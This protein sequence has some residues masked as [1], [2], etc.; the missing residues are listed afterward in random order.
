MKVT[1]KRGVHLSYA[2]K[3]ATKSLPV[4]D[5]VSDEV[6]IIM[7]MHIGAPSV[8]CVKKGDHVLLGQVIA[9]PVGFLGIPVH[10]SV[11][12]EVTDVGTIPY[13]G[14]TPVQCVTI[15][16]DFKDEWAPLTPL[17]DV[18]TVDPALIVPA[19]KNA[20]ICGMGGASFP[21]H[22]KLSPKP[23][24]KCELVIVNGAECE[25]HLTCDHRLM[26]EEGERIV[27]GLRA[28]MRALSV[29]RGVI[30]IEDNKPDAIENMRR[31]CATRSGVSVQV[32]K[33]K[34]PQGGEKQLIEAVTGRQVPVGKLPI[35][36]GAVVCNV[37]TCA[38]ISDAIRLGRPLIS[39]ITTVTGCV[40]EPANLRVRIG[41][42]AED[43]IGAC[44]GFS[45][46]A[47]KVAFGGGM[48]GLCIPNT[49]IPTAKSTNGIV[50]YNEKDAKSI[51]EGPC[52]RCGKCVAACPIGLNPYLI[53]R[54]ADA[55]RLDE[56]ARLSVN[57]CILCGCC[58]YECPSRRW[59]TA[60]F[61]IVKQ[62]LAAQA[63]AKGGKA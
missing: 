15:K 17:G 31:L 55:D 39:R 7:N 40:K 62:K 56:A 8:P 22:V 14:E 33:T 3:N 21:T 23:E 1:F 18:E 25:T 12:G 26:L 43:M 59:L 57:D 37:G 41:T 4:R 10:A 50:V 29:E 20:G 48:T 28:V 46:E 51:D 58:S 42:V 54:A 49:D 24:Q 16:N 27:D 11:S 44:G 47:G 36:V 34:Y 30:C 61:K 60:S 45:E 35:D 38:A 63:K 53:K 32:L 2:N 13:L 52:I 19:I 5:F 6:R 9:E